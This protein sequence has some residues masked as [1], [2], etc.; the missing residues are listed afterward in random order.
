MA[1]ST[2]A[3]TGQDG[4]IHLAA[5]TGL[6]SVIS[7][8]SG[9]GDASQCPEAELLK[10]IV[11]ASAIAVEQKMRCLVCAVLFGLQDA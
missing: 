9:V 1:I 6:I 11:K 8:L 4:G 2:C 3:R 10:V 7:C 5:R